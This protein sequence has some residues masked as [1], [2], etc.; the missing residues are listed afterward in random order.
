MNPTVSVII[1]CYNA[2]AWIGAA[3]ESALAQDGIAPDVIVVNDGSTDRS[4]AI[5][6]GYESQG[7]RVIDQPNRGA[8]AARNAGLRAARGAYLQYLDADDLLGSGKIRRQLERLRSAPPETIAAGSWGIFR[9]RESDA[10][11][12]PEPAWC[13]ARPVDWLVCSW[14]GG[15]MMHPAAWLV[16]RGVADRSGPWN[17]ALTLDDD[18]EYFSRVIL[19]SPGIAFVPEA[20]SFY[21]AH[22]GA[23]LSAS[24]GIRAAESSFLSCTLKEQH[25]LACEDSPRTRRALAHNYSRFAWEQ[26]EAAPELAERAIRRWRELDPALAPPRA[27]RWHNLAAAVLGWRRARS[28]QLRQRR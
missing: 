1:P 27:G 20:R 5:A 7:V 24:A 17:E 11:F 12:T 21:R 18:G 28:W 25:L 26:L 22:G 15:G 9:E 8:A 10:R 14:Q 19:A 13:D 3:I 16:P 23:R 2:A 4:L 6:R